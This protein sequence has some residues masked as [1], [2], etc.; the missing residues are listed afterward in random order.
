MTLNRLF[1]LFVLLGV[2]AVTGSLFA[3]LGEPSRVLFTAT[4]DTTPLVHDG[5]V[6]ALVVD[7]QDWAGVRRAV[8][9]LQSDFEKVV[10][11]RPELVQQAPKRAS[12]AILIGTLGK[13]AL[14]DALV[15]DGKIDA[16]AIQGKWEAW[17]TDLVDKPFDGVDRALVIVGSD[18]RG[19]I[20]GTYDLSEQIGVSP[21]HWWADVAP[22]RRE[23][24]NILPRRAIQGSPRVKYRGIFLNDE[25]PALSGWATEKF[26][27]LNSQFYRHVFELMLRVR[28]NYRHTLTI[29]HP[30]RATQH[31]RLPSSASFN[32]FANDLR[33]IGPRQHPPLSGIEASGAS[34]MRVLVRL[35][36]THLLRRSRWSTEVT[37]I[38]PRTN[39]DPSV[40]L[41]QSL[42]I[43]PRDAQ[44]LDAR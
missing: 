37:E 2:T 31:S 24:L 4:N 22:Q 18:K 35:G 33:H 21:W 44:P 36:P 40:Q 32:T 10:G 42:R 34:W 5:R 11:I 8:G 12:M 23:Q 17:M 16:T 13:S 20:Y 25:A 28:A 14:I 30:F 27:G 29:V 15:R 19:T 38:F 39:D 9:D 6:A 41:L 43:A 26:G 1:R 7:P 3:G